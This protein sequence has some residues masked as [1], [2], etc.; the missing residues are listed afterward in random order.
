MPSPSPRDLPDPGIEPGSPALQ[1]DALPSEPPG[2]PQGPL[3]NSIKCKVKSRPIGK[4]PDA[5]KDRRQE[6]KG[7]TEDEMVGWQHQLNGHQFERAPGD[8][9]GHGSL[10]VLQSTGSQRVR[11]D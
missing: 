8:G 2:K 7:T 4:A 1:A 10:A 9:E 3:G 6:E 5:G 11:H